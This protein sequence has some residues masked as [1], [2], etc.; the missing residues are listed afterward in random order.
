MT[1]S[2]ELERDLR[3]C[4]ET[5]LADPEANADALRALVHR[6]S[7]MGISSAAIARTT[8]VPVADIEKLAW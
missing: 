8:G 4:G 6:A 7:E 2:T 5:F 1:E 3:A